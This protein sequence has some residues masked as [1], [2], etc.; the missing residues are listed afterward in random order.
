MDHI[1][2]G[3]VYLVSFNGLVAGSEL[4]VSEIPRLGS[5]N[6]DPDDSHLGYVWRSPKG[7]TRGHVT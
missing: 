7:G 5:A 6:E 4:I 2:D 3:E 1:N